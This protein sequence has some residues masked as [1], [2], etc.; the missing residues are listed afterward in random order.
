MKLTKR[1]EVNP[2]TS[3]LH[4]LFKSHS[5]YN[6]KE[7]GEKP[8]KRTKRF[9]DKVYKLYHEEIMSKSGADGVADYMRNRG[10]LVRIVKE[11][12]HNEWL[13]YYRRK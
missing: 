13:I 5:A 7:Y 12:N 4:G 10:Y 1:S 2:E 11:P 9:D 3:K 6:E 8:H